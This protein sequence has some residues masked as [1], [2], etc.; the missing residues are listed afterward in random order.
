[1]SDLDEHYWRI[2]PGEMKGRRDAF[3]EAAKI[4]RKHKLT[5]HGPGSSGDCSICHELECAALAIEARAKGE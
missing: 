1:M 4:I 5:S 2:H 3:K